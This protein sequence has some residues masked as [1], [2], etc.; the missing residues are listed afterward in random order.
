MIVAAFFAIQVCII[1]FAANGPFV[2]EGAYTV[3]GLRVLEGKALSDGYLAWF[4]GSPFVWPVLAA[5]GHHLGGLP[6]ARLMAAILSLVT[7]V[8]FAKTAEA[9]FG[10]SAA[11][12]GTGAL[13]VNGLFMALAHFAVYDVPGLT[14]IALSMWCAT[15][16]SAISFLDVGDGRGRRLLP[17]RRSRSTDICSWWSPSRVFWCP[18]GASTTP[19]AP[20]R[21]FC[22]C[23]E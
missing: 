9:L 21:S 1:W 13:A 12:W 8:A 10:E 3:A 7:L 11:A 15:R 16:R 23:P 20:S 6:G 17:R 14:G 2:D 18:C 4:N 19:A 5:L 22:P